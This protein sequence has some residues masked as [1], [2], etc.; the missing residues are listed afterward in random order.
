LHFS[1]HPFHECMTKLLS[2]D[3]TRQDITRDIT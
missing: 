3:V 1:F 2:V